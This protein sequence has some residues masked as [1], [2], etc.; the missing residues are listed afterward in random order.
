[1]VLA[2]IGAVIIGQARKPDTSVEPSTT[3]VGSY[4]YVYD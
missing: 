4:T 3:I 1:M 2:I